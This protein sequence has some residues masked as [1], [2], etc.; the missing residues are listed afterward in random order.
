MDFADM[1][2]ISNAWLMDRV[3][4]LYQHFITALKLRSN[5]VPENLVEEVYGG[6]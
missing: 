4:F 2:K 3:G 6:E 1:S 5:V